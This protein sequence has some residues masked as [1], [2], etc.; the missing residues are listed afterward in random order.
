MHFHCTGMHLIF[1]ESIVKTNKL[2]G[3]NEFI[4]WITGSKKENWRTVRDMRQPRDGE[5]PVPVI[6]KKIVQS[7]GEFVIVFDIIAYRLFTF[8]CIRETKTEIF[9]N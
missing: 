2:K 9:L 1:L 3:V 7:Q 8:K 5:E 6:N 4:Q